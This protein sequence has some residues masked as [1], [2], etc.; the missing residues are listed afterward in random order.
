MGRASTTAMALLSW[1]VASCT[2]SAASVAGEST[3][4]GDRDRRF[5]DC[6]V[7]CEFECERPDARAAHLKQTDTVSIARKGFWP[8]YGANDLGPQG[9]Q[10]YTKEL[11]TALEKAML[12]GS[13]TTFTAHDGK[14]GGD[15]VAVPT[16]SLP[17]VL[18]ATRWDCEE[19]CRYECMIQNS[20]VRRTAKEK[21]VHYYGK[22]PFTRVLGV[23]ELFSSLFSLANGLPYA[24]L[25]ATWP[26]G[27]KSRTA[28]FWVIHTVVQINTWIQSAV[29]HARESPLTETLD[30]HGATLGLTVS[31]CISVGAH[32][33]EHWTPKRY[34]LVAFGPPMAFW[35]SHAFYLSFI[36]FD[37]GHNMQVAV[38][39]GI[40]S[41]LLWLLWALRHWRERPF[42][43][44]VLF[45]VI[46]PYAVLPLELLDFPPF[47]GLLD[48]HA[49]WHMG[50]VP[51]AFSWC[52]FVRQQ[53]AWQAAS[54]ELKRE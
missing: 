7:P 13:S 10:A 4:A 31:L 40:V 33:P 6:A 3:Y 14:V 29:F 9:K 19:N 30:Y 28:G 49:C 26:P 46:G 52:S 21:Q 5:L 43:W 54:S 51:M 18:R 34:A 24:I 8:R 47:F 44:K 42:V 32:L 22:W 35:M 16:G 41:T 45:A 37:Y 50:T 23:Q 2:L 38:G 1:V 12:S 17:L 20:A 36:N 11:R 39:I 53:L 48:A 27:P 25:L 15:P